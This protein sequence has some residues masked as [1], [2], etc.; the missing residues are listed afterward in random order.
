MR[1]VERARGRREDREHSADRDV[2][3]DVGG[4][5]ERI[6]RDQKRAI[7]VDSDGI[8]TLLRHDAAH[9]RPL[10]GPEERLVGEHV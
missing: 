8:I 3:V 6:D 10:Q 4:T 9:A 5:V 2:G 7:V 1:G